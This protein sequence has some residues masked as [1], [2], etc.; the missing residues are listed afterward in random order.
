MGDHDPDLKT[1]SAFLDRQHVSALPFT[2]Q[3]SDRHGRLI[4]E[5]HLYK[6]EAIGVAVAWLFVHADFT[7]FAI[8]RERLAKLPFRSP[9]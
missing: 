9:G 7:N 4:V 5:R 6:T 2:V 3:F 1:H 8:A